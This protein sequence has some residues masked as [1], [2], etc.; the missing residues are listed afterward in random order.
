V[1]F[2]VW[3]SFQR[4]WTEVLD[5][6]RRAEAQGWDGIWFPDHYMAD[7]PK[8]E[9]SDEPALECWSALAALGAAAPR[10][11]LGSLVSPSTVHHP[12]LLAHQATT[13]DVVSGGR[14][15]LGI[16][17]GWQVNEHRAYG[18]ELPPP[19]ARVDRF[20]EFI[21]ILHGLLHDKRTTFSGTYFSVVD[22]P[23]EPKGAGDPVPI[24]VGTGGPRMLRLTAR[25]AQAW[26]IWGTPERVRDRSAAL[27]QACAA[28]G[29]DPATVR[30]TAQAL[31][32][33][34]DDDDAANAIRARVPADRSVIGGAAELVDNLGEYQAAGIDEL[35]VPDFA[36]GKTSEKRRE[37]YDRF[38]NEVV[39]ASR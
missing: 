31:F 35:I 29:R 12:A 20:A 25:W 3:P 23:C 38:W 28:V 27:D 17:A 21:E 18:W 2:S 1:R 36:F 30:R 24:L 10:L 13:V 9:P 34:I 32:F 11:Q 15:V 16:G 8:G 6:A 26:N 39:L 4:E 7:D 19:K 33:L 37:A 14:V 22:A 5:L